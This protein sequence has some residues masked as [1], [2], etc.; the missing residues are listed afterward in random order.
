MGLLIDRLTEQPPRR[1][2]SCQRSVSSHAECLRIPSGGHSQHRAPLKPTVAS[3]KCKQKITEQ[4]APLAT[5]QAPPSPL[6]RGPQQGSSAA[7]KHT[8]KSGTAGARGIA[9]C[10]DNRDTAG[11][12]EKSSATQKC[13]HSAHNMLHQSCKATIRVAKQQ[14]ELQMHTS[15]CSKHTLA[16]AYQQMQQPGATTC[17]AQTAYTTRLLRFG[18]TCHK[19]TNQ[20]SDNHAKAGA[21]IAKPCSPYL[22]VLP[23]PT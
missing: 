8:N 4:Q 12:L 22:E 3:Q 11:K 19:T 15:K 18:T 14:H 9:Q 6:K 1:S 16:H 21:A 5:C 2:T 7:S 10:A 17:L 23:M 13:K 20:S